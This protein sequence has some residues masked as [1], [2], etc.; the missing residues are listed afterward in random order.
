VKD[1]DNRAEAI[2]SAMGVN[3]VGPV[4]VS[5]GYLYAP[6]AMSLKAGAEQAP[7]MPGQLEYTVSVQIAYAF[8]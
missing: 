6:V 7:V 8:T 1:A 4:S 2:A 3:L 5:I